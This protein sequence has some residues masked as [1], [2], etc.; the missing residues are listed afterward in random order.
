VDGLSLTATDWFYTNAPI[1]V[2]AGQMSVDVE[3]FDIS[4]SSPLLD[5]LGTYSG[6]YTV[7]GGADGD[8]QDNLSIA[9]FSIT[10]VPEPSSIVLMIS[11]LSGAL[12]SIS[13]R[14]RS[15]A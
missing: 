13:R 8:A 1:S 11:G 5:A 7:I 12:V 6:R 15:R 9:G 10:T 3:L 4:A 2:D 14:L